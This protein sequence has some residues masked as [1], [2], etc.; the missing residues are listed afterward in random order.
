MTESTVFLRDAETGEMVPASLFDC[1]TPQHLKLWEDEWLPAM[2]RFCADHPVRKEHPEDS[3]WDWQRKARRID[4]MLGYHSFALVCHEKLQ[5]LMVTSDIKSARLQQQFGKPIVYIHFVATAPW[6]RPEMQVPPRYRGVGQVFLLSAI[7]SSREIGYKG[8]I[9]LHSLPKSES[10]YE[11]AGMTKL[12][13]D[14]SHQNLIY[15][16]MTE[17]QADRFRRKLS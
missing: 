1:V 7:E 4:G 16:E 11:C 14:S 9:G 5:G 8:R 13:P 15:F 2:Q 17:E 12:G 6:N 10:F 3:H